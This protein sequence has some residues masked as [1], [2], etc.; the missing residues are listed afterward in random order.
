MVN[1]FSLIPLTYNTINVLLM[2]WSRLGLI[3]G[4]LTLSVKVVGRSMGRNFPEG[5]GE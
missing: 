1:Q 3:F 5:G 4:E 2:K